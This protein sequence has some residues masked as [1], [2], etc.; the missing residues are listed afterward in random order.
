MSAE[1]RVGDVPIEITSAVGEMNTGRRFDIKSPGRP[2]KWAQACW[3][4]EVIKGFAIKFHGDGEKLHTI[5]D[6]D[7][8][9]SVE[10]HRSTTDVGP[11]D[12]LRVFKISTSSF[13]YK[14]ARGLVMQSRAMTKEQ[15]SWVAGNV[16]D[17]YSN[18][19]V[20]DRYWMGIYG[21]LN[22]DNFINALGLWVTTKK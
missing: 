12:L 6:W 19:D 2:V 21:T 3:N 22:S 4:G 8:H 5:G 1:I 9:H 16:T 10:Y 20:V 11:D 17:P 7:N 18:L 15:E 14:S 13:G